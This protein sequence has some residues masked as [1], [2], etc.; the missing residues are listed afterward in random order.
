MDTTHRPLELS[1]DDSIPFIGHESFADAVPDDIL[2]LPAG[3]GM[4]TDQSAAEFSECGDFERLSDMPLLSPEGESFLFRKMNYLRYQAEQARRRGTAEGSEEAERLLQDACAVRNHIAECNLRL[5][6]SIARR[7]ATSAFDFDELMSEGNE[8]LLKAIGK[9]DFSRGFRFSTYATH[10]VQ[11]HF[12]RYTQRQ[13]RRNS[14]EMK[15]AV[16]VLNEIPDTEIDPLIAQWIAEE[17]RVTNLIAR[18]AER[19][20]EREQMV[21]AG[22]FG[23]N[24]NGV[25]RTLRELAADLG[26]SKERVRQLQLT[27][28]D[29]LR[30]LFDELEPEFAPV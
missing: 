15:S 23:L 28:V 11:R 2:Y 21:I 1:A 14:V 30:D 24:T 27:A 22:R 19:L 4:Y 10:S 29:K 17:Q 18:M 6:I 16:E 8:I 9:F 7:F 25:I 26:L 12:Y 5:V 13:R 20:D 3:T